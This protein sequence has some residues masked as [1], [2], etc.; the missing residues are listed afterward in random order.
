MLNATNG[1]QTKT[2]KELADAL[3]SQ[4]MMDIVGDKGNKYVDQYLEK[5]VNKVQTLLPDS[6]SVTLNNVKLNESALDAFRSA[7]TTKDAVNALADLIAQFNNLSIKSFAEPG[8][9][10]TVSYNG[11]TASA[12]LVIDVK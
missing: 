10:M 8:Q 7:K 5:I 2:A 4:T 11:R 9:V 3:K 1:I 12:H 6:A